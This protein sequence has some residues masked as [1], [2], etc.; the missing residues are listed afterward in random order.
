MALIAI[1]TGLIGLAA[2]CTALTAV[3]QVRPNYDR[4][5]QDLSINTET[6]ATAFDNL[7][8]DL[9]VYF[10]QTQTYDLKVKEEDSLYTAFLRIVM[11]L[12]DN[13]IIFQNTITAI[14]Y[15]MVTPDLL[16][17]T[18]VEEMADDIRK[19]DQ[20]EIDPLLSNYPVQPVIVNGSLAIEIKIP[21]LEVNKQASLFSVYPYPTFNDNQT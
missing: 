10:N 12:Q 4:H 18:E 3:A 13:L 9:K 15:D 16:S 6:V 14:Q 11:T 8:A 5:I 17:Q 20:V 21:V 7:Q 2:S 1:V 19:K